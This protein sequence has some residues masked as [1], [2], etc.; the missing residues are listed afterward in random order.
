VGEQ[1]CD[2]IGA[3]DS[4]QLQ[5]CAEV[6]GQEPGYVDVV[7][8][9]RPIDDGAERREILRNRN[10]DHTCFE[11]LVE[12]IGPRRRGQQVEKDERTNEPS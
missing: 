3:G 1:R 6:C 2:A 11:K 7:P 9:G 12:I 4:N 8:P 5:A 10:P